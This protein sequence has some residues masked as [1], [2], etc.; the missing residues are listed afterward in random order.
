[1]SEENV[2]IVRA[3]I[4]AYNRGDGEGAFRDASTGL[5][6]DLSRTTG[7]WR[8]TY[9]L[10][11]ARV[12]Y[13]EFVGMWSSARA[14]PHEFI[15]VGDDVI[16]PWTARMVGRD[17]IEVEVRVAWTFT[18]RDRKIERICYYQGKAE[19]LEAAGLSD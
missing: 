7:P 16:V 5:E 18:I 19:A 15:E 8:G 4:D 17:G 1:M 12:I 11:Q 13:E 3:A 9:G 6:Y 14:E 2:E 10:D